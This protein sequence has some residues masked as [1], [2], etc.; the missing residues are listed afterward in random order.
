MD[1]RGERVVLLRPE[2]SASPAATPTP[3][4]AS[5]PAPSRELWP[6][7]LL[8]A[9]LILLVAGGAWWLGTRQ[10]SAPPPQLPVETPGERLPPVIADP[11]AGTS[12]TPTPTGE[13]GPITSQAAPPAASRTAGAVR[14]VSP[15][16]P[17]QRPTLASESGRRVFPA[18]EFTPEPLPET[19]PAPVVIYHPQQNRGRV[20]Q[21][22]AFPTRD[23][24]ESA[25][26]R[27]VRRYPYLKTRSKM[28]NSVDVGLLGSGSR[29]TRMYRLQLGT[30]SQAQSV[31]I[32]QQLEMAG[33]SCVVVY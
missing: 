20:V 27:V 12:E 32:C 29:R 11:E 23:Q 7:Y 5:S 33:Q 2:P 21:L 13:A 22:G 25:W 3:T 30:S 4:P 31:V 17:A 10:R 28:V 1:A 24:A 26:G 19:G 18:E 8:F 6:W 16:Q 14:Q 9:L 15:F